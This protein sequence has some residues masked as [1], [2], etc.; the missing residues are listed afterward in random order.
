VTIRPRAPFW[1]GSKF[2]NIMGHYKGRVKLTQ[3]RRRF[4]KS[5]RIKA[6][7]AAKKDIP[8]SPDTPEPPNRV[9]SLK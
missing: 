3:R 5:E 9:G 8:P 1:M 7:A 2:T 6:L 4:A